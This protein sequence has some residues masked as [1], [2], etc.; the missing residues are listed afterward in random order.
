MKT[1]IAILFSIL[2]I[3]AVIY[4]FYDPSPDQW[5]NFWKK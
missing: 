1:T 4:H 2:L 5:Y 3:S